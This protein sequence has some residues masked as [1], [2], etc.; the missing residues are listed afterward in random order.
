MWKCRKQD[1]SWWSTFECLFN[2]RHNWSELFQSSLCESWGFNVKLFRRL[3]SSDSCML[4]NKTTFILAIAYPY[5][6]SAFLTPRKL[7]NSFLPPP[8]SLARPLWLIT[9]PP[10]Y[11]WHCQ[12]P[13][14]RRLSKCCFPS[15]PQY[16]NHRSM[17]RQKARLW[18]PGW[19]MLR[20]GYINS[21]VDFIYGQ[22]SLEQTM[23][24]L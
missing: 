14:T 7:W 10:S 2:N 8:P 12:P 17:P 15:L 13:V 24:F 3:D 1:L 19:L 22:S 23:F 6:R 5:W 18:D 9:S 11:V 20:A 16:F 4:R 21:N